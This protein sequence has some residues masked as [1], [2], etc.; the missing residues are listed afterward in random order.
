MG[1][2]EETWKQLIWRAAEEE[3]RTLYQE[4][5]ELCIKRMD[6]SISDASLQ[7]PHAS[8][9]EEDHFFSSSSH[10]FHHH[11]HHFLPLSFLFF[12][13]FLPLFLPLLLSSSRIAGESISF[14]TLTDEKRRKSKDCSCE[15]EEVDR[16]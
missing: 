2:K 6:S 7:S 8:S 3:E 11:H 14:V 15:K 16:T 12:F 9:M 13:L 10:P 5:K 1:R 4:E